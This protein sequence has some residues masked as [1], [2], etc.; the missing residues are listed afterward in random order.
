MLLGKPPS[1]VIV[2][3]VQFVPDFDTPEPVAANVLAYLFSATNPN[4]N[5]HQA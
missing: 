2:I 4:P 1:P 3:H 5:L